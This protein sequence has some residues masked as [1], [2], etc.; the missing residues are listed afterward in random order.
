MKS[1]IHTLS[2]HINKVFFWFTPP[3]KD[4]FYNSW[5]ACFTEEYSVHFLL[6]KNVFKSTISCQFLV[7][8]DVLKHEQSAVSWKKYIC[9]TIFYRS[10]DFKLTIS[11][12]TP[13]SYMTGNVEGHLQCFTEVGAFKKVD[14]CVFCNF[15]LIYYKRFKRIFLVKIYYRFKETSVI[16]TLLLKKYHLSRPCSVWR[17]NTGMTEIPKWIGKCQQKVLF[18]LTSIRKFSLSQVL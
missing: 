17:M 18:I 7:W 9:C 8:S 3:Y 15:L 13:S 10:G 12:I 1:K 16:L 5:K 2:T 11:N 6:I 14:P 4:T